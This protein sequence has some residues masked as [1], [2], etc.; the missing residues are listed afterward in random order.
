MNF[1]ALILCA[2]LVLV[3]VQAL[4]FLKKKAST[5]PSNLPPGP[6]PLPVIGN[7]LEL[8][9]LPH[10]SLAKLARTYGPII[11]LQLGHVTTIVVSSPAIAREILQ[12]HD[13]I[14]SNRTIPDSITALRQDELGLPWLPV[15]PLWRN[16]RKICNLHIFSHKKL[17]SDQHIRHKKVQELVGYIKRSLS[18]GD[19]IDI[20]E[21]A[22]KTV[23]NL[24]SKTMLSEDLADPSDL[25]VAGT[26]TTLSTLEWSLSEL[27]HSL[28]KLSR[29]QAE[30][31]RVIGKGK[32]I[33]ES[34]IARMPYLQAIIKETLRMHPPVPLYLPRKSGLEI[35]IGGFTVPKGAQVLVNVWAIGRDPSIWKDPDV[36]V[37]ERF[38]GSEID[39]KGQD[40]ELAPFGAGRR[41][42]PGLPLALRILHWMLGSLINSFNWELEGGVKP[43]DM[44]MDEKFGITLQR[45]QPL[46]VI[47]KPV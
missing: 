10:K 18:T 24:L 37:P 3:L 16:L 2:Y 43:E 38:L 9:D 32:P 13:A 25:F 6:P 11:K 8:G 31:N 30:L 42:C 1:L 5:S 27:L 15:S 46:R 20:G 23:V 26:D 41:I 47:P 4:R 19:A 33:E 36:F 12:T 39:V 21:V 35:E 28:E 17:E 14:F 40:F 7:L 29:A 34:E 22:F 45:A 44:C